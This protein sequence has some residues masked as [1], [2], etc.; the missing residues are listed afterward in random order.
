[1]LHEGPCI[2]RRAI[3]SPDG[4]FVATATDFYAARI[5]D[6][7]NGQPVS[8]WLEHLEKAKFIQDIAFTPDSRRL[9]STDRDQRLRV[10]NLPADARS[11][12]ELQKFSE[13]LSGRMLDETGGESPLRPEQFIALQKEL[14]AA[15]PAAF[16]PPATPELAATA[17]A[18]K[19][20]DGR[21][22]AALGDWYAANH[23]SESAVKF[24][25]AAR[26]RGQTINDAQLAYSYWAAGDDGA[27]IE[28]FTSALG[29]SP[30]P[31]VREH[32]ERCLNFLKSHR[33]GRSASAPK[34]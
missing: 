5:W 24:Y 19:D 25:E 22:L 15:Y 18:S 12:D 30:P 2:V 11:I 26:R 29:A 8:G 32:L 6:A 10:W 34:E 3:F 31:I 17:L 9:V 14:T 13:L 27:A 23:A 21:M 4:C 33:N 7:R 20:L 16:L 28:A 1:M